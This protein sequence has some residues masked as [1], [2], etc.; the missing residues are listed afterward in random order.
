MP[1]IVDHDERRRQVAR[2][3]IGLILRQGVDGVS[4]RA[5]AREAGYS[6]AIVSHYFRTKADLL[7]LAY[8]T[9]LTHAGGRVETA[10][11]NGEDI[12]ATLGYL[13]PLD[14]TGRD[15][16]KIWFAFWGMALSD[17]SFQREQIKQGR[18]AQTLIARALEQR[19]A[20]P[21]GAGGGRD[22]QARR[23]LAMIAGLATQATYD[24]EAWPPERQ[25]AILA[26]ELASIAAA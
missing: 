17:E 13:L 10:L 24:P 7:L 12:G 23:L 1:L 2:I 18:E 25:R 20:I 19:T 8:Q 3:T 5:I 16:W 21:A 11:A 22:M 4:V 6:T 14:Q 15:N 26:A 9:T